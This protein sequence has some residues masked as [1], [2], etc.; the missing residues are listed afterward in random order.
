M[1]HTC[2]FQLLPDLLDEFPSAMRAPVR[3]LVTYESDNVLS[4]ISLEKLSCVMLGQMNVI[5]RLQSVSISVAV[6]SGLLY[7]TGDLELSSWVQLYDEITV[8]DI[9]LNDGSL[10][11]WIIMQ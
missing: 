6:L 9:S 5:R 10:E 1:T 11:F 2:S 4:R 7:S 3:V 8:H